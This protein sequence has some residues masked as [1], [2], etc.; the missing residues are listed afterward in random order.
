MSADYRRAGESRYRHAEGWTPGRFALYLAE[1]GDHAR[2]IGLQPGASPVI[3]SWLLDEEG[4]IAGVSRLR[5]LLTEEL[6][7]E[8]GNIGYDVP[9]SRRRQGFGTE[10]LRRTLG[11][12]R[13]HGLLRVL[14]TCNSDNTPSRRIIERCGG[15]LAGEGISDEDGRPVVRFWI[16]LACP[17]GELPSA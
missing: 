2:G 7:N 9:P 15:V 8:G 11:K 1:L 13:E 3:T 16:D 17:P 6:M 4:R 12:A 10:L 14:V 5:T